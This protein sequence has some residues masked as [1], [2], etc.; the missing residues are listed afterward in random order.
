MIPT[1]EKMKSRG[2]TYRQE[3]EAISVRPLVFGH[4]GIHVKVSGETGLDLSREVLTLLV[5]F[6][7]KSIYHILIDTCK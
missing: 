4:Q 1:S 5:P 3:G 2:L 6:I 7:S